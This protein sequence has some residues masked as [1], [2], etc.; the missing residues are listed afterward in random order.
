MPPKAR[1]DTLIQRRPP[2]IADGSPNIDPKTRHAR[3]S[4]RWATFRSMTTPIKLGMPGRSARSTWLVVMTAAVIAGCSSGTST[5]ATSDNGATSVVGSSAAT[6]EPPTDQISVASSVSDALP[7]NT[8]S[9]NPATTATIGDGTGVTDSSRAATAATTAPVATVADT[10]ASTGPPPSD[11]SVAAV[12]LLAYVVVVDEHRG[13]YNRELFGYPI[14][15]N[16]DGCNTRDEILKRDSL[17]PVQ[18]DLVGCHIV[19]GDWLSPYDG[20]TVSDPS[21]IEIDHVVALKEAWDSGAWNWSPEQRTAYANDLTDSRTLRAVSTASNLSKG[22]RDPSNW[23][24]S[25]AADVCPFIGDWLAIK[26]RWALTMDQSEYGRIRNLLNAGC[27]G[28]RINGPTAL[29]HAIAT[30]PPTGQTTPT[31]PPASVYYNNCAA[32]RAAGVAPLH[33]GEPGYRTGLDRD[34]DGVACE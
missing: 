24:P 19:A 10:A 18:I 9:D 11:G 25:D 29:P 15:A 5:P 12:D 17:S 32:A 22:D 34:K 30:A 7:S 3:R 14:D 6:P 31:A 23:L 1:F 33:I 4:R 13:G 28:W 26:V 27:A 21:E 20:I 16:G 8:A 2:S